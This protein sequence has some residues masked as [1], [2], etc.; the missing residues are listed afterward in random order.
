VRVRLAFLP[1]RA[2]AGLERRE[3]AAQLRADIA[4]ALGVQPA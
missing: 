1:A 4:G 3:L 2:S